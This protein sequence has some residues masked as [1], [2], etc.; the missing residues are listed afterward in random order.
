YPRM[1][2]DHYAWFIG[3]ALLLAIARGASDAWSAGAP[4]YLS[5]WT[6]HAAAHFAGTLLVVQLVAGWIG[7]LQ[8]QRLMADLRT[9]LP[10]LLL[11]LGVTAA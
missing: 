10:W 5:D 6:L 11:T 3:V 8:L 2:A 7:R 4:V 9:V 1:R